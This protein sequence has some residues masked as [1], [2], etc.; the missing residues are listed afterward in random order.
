LEW[1]CEVLE[2]LRAKADGVAM[3]TTTRIAI[4]VR[5]S[6]HPQVFRS[7]LAAV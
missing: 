1:C 3:S 4:N 2:V 5:I 7:L 6:L